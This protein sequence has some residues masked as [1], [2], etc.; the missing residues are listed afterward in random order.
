MINRD[1]MAQD[2]AMSGCY[3]HSRP[4]TY[5]VYSS[6]VWAHCSKSPWYFLPFASAF[7]LLQPPSFLR[8]SH[9][10]AAE[11]TQTLSAH[12]WNPEP[13]LSHT[14]AIY[15]HSQLHTP[16][17]YHPLLVLSQARIFSPPRATSRACAHTHTPI[18]LPLRRERRGLKMGGGNLI[19]AKCV[20]WD[21]QMSV[22]LSGIL[23]K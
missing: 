10:L 2:C 4:R 11:D 5:A 13:I 8:I 12:T 3:L 19:H 21:L 17:W 6:K 22:D 23:W 18:T 20:S 14:S 1:F 16:T 7:V 9:T 15:F